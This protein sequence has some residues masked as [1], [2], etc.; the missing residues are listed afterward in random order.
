MRI[1]LSNNPLSHDPEEDFDALIKLKTLLT[2]GL[3]NALDF[4]HLSRSHINYVDH[5]RFL[6]SSSWLFSVDIKFNQRP[7]RPFSGVGPFRG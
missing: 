3:G 1:V 2:N 6:G 4:C 5:L 7:L